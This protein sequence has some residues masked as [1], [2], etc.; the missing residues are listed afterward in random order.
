M[1]TADAASL[2]A[3]RCAVSICA[4]W[5]NSA[6]GVCPRCREKGL[7]LAGITP[8]PP[9][10]PT[11]A[12]RT[13]A[14]KQASA[15]GGKKERNEIEHAMQVALVEWCKTGEGAELAPA[16]KRIVAIPNGGSATKM[17]N[18][19]MWQEGRAKGFPDLMLPVPRGGYN[20]AFLELKKPGEVPTTE[21]F[22]WLHS[23]DAD[24]YATSWSDAVEAAQRWLL[25]Y[26]QL[27]PAV[28]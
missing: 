1:T 10:D 2:N 24:G 5:T 16:L 28:E 19:R 9:F 15:R 21:Q 20:G 14:G 6:S 23:L 3:R 4:N 27:P 8:V 17:M 25:R 12:S 13:T 7:V 11:L 22:E 18:I 26:G